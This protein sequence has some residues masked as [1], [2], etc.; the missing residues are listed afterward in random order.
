MNR[1]TIALAACLAIGGMQVM[2]E[3]ALPVQDA[4]ANGIFSLEEMQVAMPD[5]TAET[6]AAVDTNADGGVDATELTAALAA[7][8]IK[9]AT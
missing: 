6:Y 4:D 2:A 3:D 1:T 7:G 5:L 8:T 9:P